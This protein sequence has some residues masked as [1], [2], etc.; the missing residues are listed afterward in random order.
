[1]FGNA[2]IGRLQDFNK[3]SNRHDFRERFAGTVSYE[4]PEGLLTFDLDG[5]L[6][7]IENTVSQSGQ[8]ALI[9]EIS[10]FVSAA[11]GPAGEV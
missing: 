5:R 2:G 6:V 11:P 4:L 3:S 9:E 10:G 7:D 1:M 8:T